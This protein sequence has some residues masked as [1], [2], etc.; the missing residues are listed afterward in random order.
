MSDAIYAGPKCTVT[1]RTITA[2]GRS[3]DITSITALDL[4]YKSYFVLA[5]VAILL[6]CLFRLQVFL[7]PVWRGSDI[8][9]Q[10]FSIFMLFIFGYSAFYE[11]RLTGKLASGGTV[12]ILDRVSPAEAR[13][14]MAAFAAAKASAASPANGAGSA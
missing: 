10:A 2:S 9:W 5:S 12:L 1:D 4:R 11:R 8:L 14:I 6:W 3:Y 13:S 7:S